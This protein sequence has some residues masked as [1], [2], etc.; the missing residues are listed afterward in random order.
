MVRISP[1]AYAVIRQEAEA[2][3]PKES[4]GFLL[5]G[6]GSVLQAIPS[7][8]LAENPRHAF[9]LD[10]RLHLELQRQSR[11]EGLEILG[12]YHS[13]P[14]GAAFPSPADLAGMQGPA[15]LCL[16]VAVKDTGA[17][18]MRLFRIKDGN[19]QEETMEGET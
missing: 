16:I 15:L 7:P 12:F 5:G 11:A 14:E 10:S 2:A 1:S 18:E 13:H 19:A 6:A 8:N 3:Y 4:C 9:M 17:G